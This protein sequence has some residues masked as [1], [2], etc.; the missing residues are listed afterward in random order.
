MQELSALVATNE[1]LE[2]ELKDLQ[3][4]SKLSTQTTDTNHTGLEDEIRRLQAQNAALQK[5]LTACQ[6]KIEKFQDHSQ[7]SSGS[8]DAE[9]SNTEGEKPIR[10][11]KVEDEIEEPSE[12][13]GYEL[14]ALRLQLDTELEEKRMLRD[15]ILS[16]EQE[17]NENKDKSE[18]LQ[19]ELNKTSERLKKKQESIITLQ[20]EKEKL[21]KDTNQ[22]LEELQAARERDQKYYTDQ[23]SKLQQEIQKNKQSLEESHGSSDQTIKHLQSQLQSLQQQVNASDIVSNQKMR[24]YSAKYEKES[25][26]LRN[27]LSTI[28]QQKEDLEVQL[29]ASK[30][31]NQEA[32]EQLSAVQQERDTQIQQWQEVNKVAEKRKSMLDELANKYQRDSASHQEKVRKMEDEHE[33]E[34]RKL[35]EKLNAER[36]RVTDLE[37]LKIQFEELKQQVQ[38]LEEAKGW[39]ERRLKETEEQFALYKEDKE[40]EMNEVL[41]KHELDMSN[42]REEHVK[43]QHSM[44]EEHTV[45][46]TEYEDKEKSLQLALEVEKQHVERLKQQLKDGVDE[47]KLHEKKGLKTLRDLKKQLHAERK[48][49]EKLQEKLQ[50]VLIDGKHN[51]SVEELLSS[52]DR[53]D[54][55]M[56]DKSSVSSWNT[57]HSQANTS[58][59]SSPQTPEKSEPFSSPSNSVHVEAEHNELLNRLAGLQ[60]ANWNLEEKVSHLEMSNSAMAE[61]LI[62]KTKIIEHYVR[63]TG[64][65]NDS[66]IHHPQDDK[67]T[68]KK[69]LD[70]VNKSDEQNLKEMNRKLQ[71]M[72]EETLTKNMH[73]EQNLEAMSIEVVRLSKLTS[74]DSETLEG[75]V[76]N[77]SLESKETSE[78]KNTSAGTDNESLKERNGES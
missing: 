22:K 69:V 14:N 44:V 63:D 35:Q 39:L 49:A 37:K 71:R 57:G 64:S 30:T 5:N 29:E 15:K 59:V 52:V 42:I 16:I 31:A 18:A 47:K 74:R 66:K 4:N 8:P 6:E 9:S 33:M 38:S 65:K 13:H 27:Q 55:L 58:V 24:D 36:K 76:K 43:A 70:L 73:L 19:E 11:I 75:V 34:V 72:L 10:I 7:S 40:S 45:K 60:Q 26:E 28:Q 17:K 67:L 77:C 23:I 61:D 54:S 62:Q 78:S 12:E 48:R 46:L 68:L 20:Q 50:E 32:L 2:K 21:F 3:K 53:N 25:G 51:K 1:V 41:H 56:E